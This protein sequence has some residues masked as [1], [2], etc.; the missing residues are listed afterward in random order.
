MFNAHIFLGTIALWDGDVRTALQ[1]LRA[2][3]DVPASDGVKY[4]GGIA[5]WRLARYLLKAG[6][7]RPWRSTTTGWRR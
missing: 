7:T 6:D 2:A 5:S 4:A 3:P 1:H